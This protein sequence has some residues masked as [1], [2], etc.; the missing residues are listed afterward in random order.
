MLLDGEHLLS[1]AI[2]AGIPLEVIAFGHEAVDGR[3]AELA[4]AARR[5]N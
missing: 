5:G 3:L 4:N 1:D 2:A